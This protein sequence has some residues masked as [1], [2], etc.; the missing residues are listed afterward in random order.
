MKRI[1]TVGLC[2][3]AMVAFG[4]M[5]ASSAYAGEYG[6][7]VKA[8]PKGSGKFTSS[9]CEILAAKGKGKYNWQAVSEDERHFTDSSKKPIVLSTAAG[10]ISCKKSKSEGEIKGWQANVD[11]WD[12]EDCTYAGAPCASGEVPGTIRT[13]LLDSFLLDHG[14]I[15]PDG[16]EPKEGE[17][18]NIL[19]SSEHEPYLMEFHC[20]GILIRVSGSIGA[21]I[22][23][24]L[25][26]MTTKFTW[27]FEKESPEQSLYGEYNTGGEWMPL[28]KGTLTGEVSVVYA[29]KVEVRPCNEPNAKEE[30][31]KV[32]PCEH[33]EPLP[34]AKGPS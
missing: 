26:K 12:L 16:G 7:C 3:V 30:G 14:T 19:F 17:V 1:S 20:G 25:S 13:N 34:W 11:I 27:K 5:A 23:K 6:E 15:G 18:W 10:E 22:T 4:A 33:E 31:K 8:S 29:S 24:I 21:N 9:T 28:G 32:I 2:L